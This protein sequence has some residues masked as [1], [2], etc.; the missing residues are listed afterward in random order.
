[1]IKEGW[2]TLREPEER[3][4][5]HFAK[6]LPNVRNEFLILNSAPLVYDGHYIHGKIIP[7]DGKNCKVCAEGIGK[8]LRYCFGVYEY[9][10]EWR[11]V[12]ELS[13]KQAEA[14]FNR[15]LVGDDARGLRITIRR[16][17]DKKTSNLQITEGRYIKIPDRE[18]YRLVDVN[19]FLENCWRSLSISSY[20]SAVG[21]QASSEKRPLSERFA[22]KEILQ[23]REY[24]ERYDPFK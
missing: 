6:I 23:S 11:G 22:R 17:S 4:K 14:I 20:E 12:L 24:Q 9:R 13:R 18:I 15:Y 2:G 5:L 7:C 3:E 16:L 1:M 10:T 19:G 8:Q 21:G